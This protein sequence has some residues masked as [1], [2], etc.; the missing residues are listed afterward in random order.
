MNSIPRSDRCSLLPHANTIM[1]TV[2]ADLRS[3]ITQPWEEED[4]VELLMEDDFPS[5]RGVSQPDPRRALEGEELEIAME[6][7]SISDLPHSRKRQR[8]WHLRINELGSNDIDLI[9]NVLQPLCV[10]LVIGEQEVGKHHTT[11]HHHIHALFRQQVTRTQI[12]KLLHPVLAGKDARRKDYYVEPAKCVFDDR[13]T[14]QDNREYVTKNGTLYEFYES[15]LGRSRKRAAPSSTAWEAADEAKLDIDDPATVDF[16]R[17]LVFPLTMTDVPIVQ[18]VPKKYRHEFAR[19]LVRYP[20]QSSVV[21]MYEAIHRSYGHLAGLALFPE[22][23][24]TAPAVNVRKLNVDALIQQ[25]P[26]SEDIEFFWIHGPAGTGKTSFCSLLYPGHYVKNKSTEYWESY[27]FLDHSTNNPHMCVV[28]NELDSANDLLAFSTNQK[29]FDAIKNILD[30][31]PFAIEIKHKNQEMIRP[32]RIYITSNTTLSSIMNAVRDLSAH[33]TPNNIFYGCNVEALHQALSRR[34]IQ[35]HIDELLDVYGLF[36]FKKLPGL[37]FG[38]VFAKHLEESI[39]VTLRNII[40][41]TPGKENFRTRYDQIASA[42]KE[43]E[44]RTIDYLAQY[45]WIPYD[46][47]KTSKESQV[48]DSELLKL[49]A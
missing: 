19:W 45:R 2:P 41:S 7:N 17:N 38:G 46:I 25:Y 48:S 22:T 16:L 32:R 24:Y 36:C 40:E 49:L 29:S 20:R 42:R 6:A 1:A 23:Y 5:E 35:V 15:S 28:F 37:P 47:V 44:Q 30:V 3:P 43:F 27:N 39:K 21:A 11:P 26:G 9:I 12:L 34:L 18:A 10:E 8:C 33:Q 31:K 4:L 13:Y 14:I